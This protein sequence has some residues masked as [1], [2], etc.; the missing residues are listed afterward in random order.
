MNPIKKL[1]NR[2]GMTLIEVLLVVALMLILLGIAVPDLISE[3]RAIK[4]AGMNGNA[5]AVA[6]AIQSKLYG[7]KNKGTAIGS[8]FER[9]NSASGTTYVMTGEGGTD[10]RYFANFG[11]TQKTG[12]Q[13]LSGAL[14][15]IELLKKGKI[16]VVYSPITADVLEVFYG[17]DQFLDAED[18]GTEEGTDFNSPNTK[19]FP[20]ASESYLADNMIGSY[21]GEPKPEL[22]RKDGLPPFTAVWRYDDELYL[23]LQM[24][25]GFS[26]E[27]NE[28]WTKKLGIEVYAEIPSARGSRKKEEVLIYAEGMF[29]TDYTA[30]SGETIKADYNDNNLTLI[31]IKNHMVTETV[32]E[33]GKETTKTTRKSGILRFAFDSLITTR[34]YWGQAKSDLR[35]Q[36]SPAVTTM[37]SEMLY[38]RESITDWFN[39]S[40]NPYL[41]FWKERDVGFNE[42]IWDR[43]D[44]G[45]G[46]MEFINVNETFRLHVK[47]YVLDDET[48]TI[49]GSSATVYPRDETYGVLD[50]R[51]P[52]ITPY[53]Y[54]LSTA[55]NKVTLSS[56][57]DLNNLHY[58]FETVNKIDTAALAGDIT[59]QQLYDKIFKVHKTLNDTTKGTYSNWSY[60]SDQDAV[61]VEAN[62]F[63]NKTSFTLS[64]TKPRG[65]GSYKIVSV[66][67]GGRSPDLGGLFGYAENCTFKDLDIVNPKVLR[68]SSSRSVLGDNDKDNMSPN[69]A[70]G[71]VASGALAAIA[72][73]CTFTNVRAYI[74]PDETLK[75]TSNGN[76]PREKWPNVSITGYRV[77]GSV[78]GGL[79]GVAVG[80]STVKT[81]YDESSEEHSRW[82]WVTESTTPTSTTFTNCVASTILGPEYYYPP[83]ECFV[84]GGLIGATVGDVQIKNSY[85]SSQLSA[86]YA[87][88]LVGA[89]GSVGA[90][91]SESPGKSGGRDWIISA[92][93][94]DHGTFKAGIATGKLMIKNSFAAGV[95]Q[96][97]VRV[98]GGLIAHISENAYSPKG[99]GVTELPVD[100]TDCYSAVRWKIVPPVAYGTFEGDNS[101][102][103]LYPTAFDLPVTANVVARFT[104]DHSN[105]FSLQKGDCGIACSGA[106]LKNYLS[107]K[108]EHG[109]TVNVWDTPQ[110]TTTWKYLEF[111]SGKDGDIKTPYPFLMPKGNVEF[112]GNWIQHY[113]TTATSDGQIQT[114]AEASF[115]FHSYYAT[116]YNN[117]WS[118][119]PRNVDAGAITMREI[120]RKEG[121]IT[122]DGNTLD[123]DGATLT[124]ANEKK[125]Y[126]WAENAADKGGSLYCGQ[127]VDHGE[128]YG[129]TKITPG[130]E[131]NTID[132]A[133]AT[134]YSSSYAPL[135]G[136]DFHPGIEEKN[137]TRLMWDH[138]GFYL[139]LNF[140]PNKES[141]NLKYYITVKDELEENLWEIVKEEGGE[142]KV[143]NLNEDGGRTNLSYA[144]I[145]VNKQEFEEAIG[146][147]TITLPMP[148]ENTGTEKTVE[149]TW[150]E[151]NGLHV[152][153]DEENG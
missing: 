129:A 94:P 22:S 86:Y 50:I 125:S 127:G 111:G 14:T 102:Y 106:M 146:Y 55:Q 87:G 43:I 109:E 3:S 21:F 153:A 4:L 119:Y 64:G 78:V 107:K 103:Y 136:S 9:L 123:G 31:N 108:G 68:N 48:E 133:S 40:V 18:S 139:L 58:V 69:L 8:E 140:D 132:F 1:K 66:T 74:D 91:G 99:E 89:V 52:N 101:N 19:L 137:I 92:N 84:A 131:G 121:T 98:G 85:A 104:T 53:F 45:A 61:Q 47:M 10:V 130:T 113:D 13:M 56:V 44:R 112:W 82:T 30:S 70:Y 145:T 144:N 5:R 110:E 147:R 71:G 149:I 75:A 17:E 148:K 62:F 72:V 34:A 90:D 151:K 28:L 97:M 25:P 142:V 118:M 16:V 29:A 120:T 59:A 63:K 116:Y 27:S 54:A 73:N 80:G 57:R 15:D 20:A 24:V 126:Y 138:Y 83:T 36:S 115:T 11:N 81:Y 135:K 93:F 46:A 32:T 141:G 143:F 7:M 114:G 95:I 79:V 128:V 23:E 39:K 134:Y 88:G 38:P 2:R 122:I 41:S 42:N 49:E 33:E 65:G 12:A 76:L 152:K 124:E 150:N 35:H 6:V 51:S 60:D 100:V 37:M 67:F 105:V 96:H 117:P 77:S 26:D